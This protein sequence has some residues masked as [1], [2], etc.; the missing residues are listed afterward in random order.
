VDRQGKLQKS[1]A[2]DG[3]MGCRDMPFFYKGRPTRRGFC[4]MVPCPQALIRCKP[5][6]SVHHRCPGPTGARMRVGRGRVTSIY[7]DQWMRFPDSR[8][9]LPLAQSSNECE[10]PNFASCIPGLPY[11]ALLSV[12]IAVF[13]DYPHTL[14]V[15]LPA[16]KPN[17]GKSRFVFSAVC[18]LARH[19]HWI[20]TAA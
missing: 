6:R 4:T 12:L 7:G 16:Q 10:I 15:A 11:C 18:S 3:K 19:R 1:H 9:P 8:H 13:C 2:Q 17:D 5:S 20:S 14:G